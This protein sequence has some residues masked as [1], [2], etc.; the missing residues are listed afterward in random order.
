[1]EKHTLILKNY[2]LKNYGQKNSK[3][4]LGRSAKRD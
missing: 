4:V 1:M 3:K 2:L